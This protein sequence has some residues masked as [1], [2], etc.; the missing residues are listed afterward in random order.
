M[1]FPELPGRSDANTRPIHACRFEKITLNLNRRRDIPVACFP[2]RFSGYLLLVIAQEDGM[3]RD[4]YRCVVIH[5]SAVTGGMEAFSRCHVRCASAFAE[6]RL[7]TAHPL[8]L[9]ESV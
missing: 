4:D 2:P 5:G 6:L 8:Q 1:R 7:A 9:P 3:V